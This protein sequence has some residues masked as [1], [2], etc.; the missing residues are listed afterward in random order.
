MKRKPLDQRKISQILGS[1]MV[2]LR[3]D[4]I[5]QALEHKSE[6]S[7][8]RGLLRESLDAF[9]YDPN[10]DTHFDMK[11]ICHCTDTGTGYGDGILR[12]LFCRIYHALE[13]KWPH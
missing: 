3:G 4:G 8:L 12:C 1:T 10:S 2:P 11:H 9:L 7:T 5:Q 13:G 6:L